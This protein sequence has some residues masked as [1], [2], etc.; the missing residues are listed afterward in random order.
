MLLVGVLDLNVRG[1]SHNCGV[2]ICYQERFGQPKLRL[3]KSPW[4]AALE[5]GSVE[6]A[7][8][9]LKAPVTPVIDS[10]VSAAERKVAQTSL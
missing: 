3:V 9:E 7:F 4:E 5:T 8:E 2:I 6:T 10:V 1:V